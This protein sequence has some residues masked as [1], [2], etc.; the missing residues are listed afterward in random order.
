MKVHISKFKFGTKEG[1]GYL[2]FRGSTFKKKGLIVSFHNLNV[3]IISWL[4]SAYKNIQNSVF[5]FPKVQMMKDEEIFSGPIKQNIIFSPVFVL[6]IR[7]IDRFSQFIQLF[8]VVAVFCIPE[9]YFF[10]GLK[11]SWVYTSDTQMEY[12][13]GIY[14][15]CI[16]SFN[17]YLYT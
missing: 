9:H 11:V 10:S 5:G 2:D 8:F 12:R 14:C 15:L 1:D 6:S 13:K 4:I 3:N 7:F 17:F 16:V